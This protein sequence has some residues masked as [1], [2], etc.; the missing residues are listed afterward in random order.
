LNHR[1]NNELKEIDNANTPS[2]TKERLNAITNE[3]RTYINNDDAIGKAEK[4][5]LYDACRNIEDWCENMETDDNVVPNT[6]TNRLISQVMS[7]NGNS[8]RGYIENY[9]ENMNV[10]DS[11]ALRRY[12]TKNEPGL[13]F[14]FEVEKPQ[15]LGGG[16]Q[17]VFLP[18]NQ[19]IFLN[20]AE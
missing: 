11:L 15:S 10:R 13:N 1:D 18:F 17:K 19:F 6:L 5:K 8:N 12:I 4:T 7:I 2:I 16:S 3:L 9:V 14:E 20:I